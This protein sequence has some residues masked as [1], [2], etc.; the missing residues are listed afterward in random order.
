MIRQHSGTT[1]PVKLTPM[2]RQYLKG[3]A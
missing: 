1:F 2:V 3:E